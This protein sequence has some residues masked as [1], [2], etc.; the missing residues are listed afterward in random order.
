MRVEARWLRD[1]PY[2]LHEPI[3]IRLTVTNNEPREHTI[4]PL[5]GHDFVPVLH[6]KDLASEVTRKVEPVSERALAN[7]TYVPRRPMQSLPP[8]GSVEVTID[9]AGRANLAR[10]GRFEL[11]IEYWWD[12]D[13][14]ISKPIPFEILTP[15]FIGARS[16]P[17][18][19]RGG[20]VHVAAWNDGE[21][22]LVRALVPSLHWTQYWCEDAGAIPP[23]AVP[24]ASVAPPGN[25]GMRFHLAW[26]ESP[27][28]VGWRFVTHEMGERGAGPFAIEHGLDTASLALPAVTGWWSPGG[29]TPDGYLAVAGRS[30]AGWALRWYVLSTGGEAR[31]E[32][33]VRLP[34][35]PV[36]ARST[37]HA[38]GVRLALIACDLG[39]RTVLGFSRRR[40]FRG[41]SPE[42]GE[43]REIARIPAPV[44]GD[45]LVGDGGEIWGAALV[46]TA[47]RGS[48]GKRQPAGWAV[49][50]FRTVD[51][52][53]TEP[54]GEAGL[55]VPVDLPSDAVVRAFRL[56]PDASPHL[57]A[58][59]GG[60]LLHVRVADGADVRK[61]DPPLEGPADHL[62]L[63]FKRLDDPRILW[64][65]RG[66]GFRVHRIIPRDAR[67]RYEPLVP[68][69]APPG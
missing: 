59:A 30:E 4:P 3:S 12:E 57:L 2:R 14:F 49:V 58:E 44:A 47:P 31:A 16:G 15:R 7:P 40:S 67:I 37:V 61:V 54:F 23:D 63:V 36:W 39:G 19:D 68:I 5:S 22:L 65:E 9:V 64:H 43:F 25:A 26:S 42:P 62:D 33:D 66:G 45:V 20:D 8:G 6:V 34:G 55:A 51:A 11:S 10:P 41:A 38:T 60:D 32:P 50:P 56:G 13:R 21:R 69:S 1:G 17:N 18:H 27:R 52:P 46:R 28:T 29:G 48:N 53:P 24:T 35:K